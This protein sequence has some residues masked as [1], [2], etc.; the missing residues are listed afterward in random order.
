MILETEQEQQAQK[1]FESY[2]TLEQKQLIDQKRKEYP[3][4]TLTEDS[5]KLLVIQDLMQNQEKN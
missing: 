1:E 5:L 4:P 2:S 3:M